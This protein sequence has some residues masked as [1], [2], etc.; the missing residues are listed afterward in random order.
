[1]VLVRHILLSAL[2][3]VSLGAA[4]QY[5]S[6]PVWAFGSHA[7]LDFNSGS[8]VPITTGIHTHSTSASTQC[9]ASGNI[10][11][12]ANG[13][14]IW[15]RAGNPM[16]NGANPVW[17]GPYISGWNMNALIVPHPVDV[18]KYFVFQ[19]FPSKGDAPWGPYFTGQLTYSVVDMTLNGGMGDV[20]SGQAHIQLD[21]NTGHYMTIVPGNHCNYWLIV[22]N[23]TGGIYVFHTYEIDGTGVHAAPVVSSFTTV[24]SLFPSGS[25]I[26]SVG[27]RAGSYV[28]SY[29][30]DKLI[31]AYESADITAYD[32]DRTSGK[33][34]NPKP[35]TWAYPAVAPI[36]SAT[37][38][39][40]CLSEDESQLYVLGQA[41]STNGY[42]LRQFP[43]SGTG[44]AFAAGTPVVLA[45]AMG[46]PFIVAQENTG[47]AWLQGA[48][49]RGPDDK[50][51]IAYTLGQNFLGRIEQPN[52]AG[53][54]CNYVPLALNLA[55]NTYTTSG[56]PGHM[57]VRKTPTYTQGM[58]LDTAV[59]FTN[60][61]V[62]QAP[63]KNYAYYQWHDGT[64][65]PQYGATQNGTYILTS[66][67]GDCT[68]R[69][70]TFKVTLVNYTVSL[71]PDEHTCEVVSLFP[72]TNAPPPITYQWNTGSTSPG[73]TVKE[74]GMYVI[75]V[76][77]S[78][79]SK[80][81][82]I[83]IISEPL[84]LNLPDDTTICS[85]TSIRLTV[86]LAADS[87]LWQDGSKLAYL[88]ASHE[89][90]Y[91]VKVVKDLCTGYD[92]TH[93]HEVDCSDCKPR[94]PSAFSPNGDGLN[95]IFRVMLRGYCKVEGF[96][97][98]IYNRYGEQVFS[99]VT[100][101]DGWDGRYKG[102]LCDM[103]TYM[104]RVEYSAG[105]RKYEGKGDVVLIW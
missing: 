3:L 28:Y 25:G 101:Q 10:L 76:S 15:D 41:T 14:N 4:G 43:L 57:Y 66:G 105:G 60:P 87:Y 38:P 102:S 16:P 67:N 62:L 100:P 91:Y 65:G 2:L 27:N 47:F 42:E 89:G 95:D 20:V 75:T 103:G 58:V 52:L 61:V 5:Q 96:T 70:D 83:N 73:L 78:G 59:C 82:T 64:A 36:N 48:M 50:I 17:P 81:D 56:L 34:S 69:N 26:K 86:D 22:Q 8:P 13:F 31:A 63:D 18:N 11:F 49:Q 40:I 79:C 90:V 23:G 44:A 39:A 19:T 30:R 94:I 84:T 33:V 51:Y 77:S 80:S 55:P 71:G 35:L 53:T 24:P 92:T 7:G 45:S 29:K 21:K 6:A 1:M 32:F 98:R 97:I 74:P 104:Y 37:L 72:Q 85:H 99:S 12:Y 9:D 46:L 54:A 88:D 68:V 93:V